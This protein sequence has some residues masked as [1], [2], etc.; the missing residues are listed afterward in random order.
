MTEMTSVIKADPE[1]RALSPKKWPARGTS[2]KR[3][4]FPTLSNEARQL[5]DILAHGP[6]R[7]QRMDTLFDLA[8]K[9]KICETTKDLEM[10]LEELRSYDGI[11]IQKGLEKGIGFCSFFR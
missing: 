3:F 2:L 9:A 4:C 5:A 8:Q 6:K 10:V 7:E 11:T 1:K